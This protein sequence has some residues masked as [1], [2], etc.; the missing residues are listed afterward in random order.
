MAATTCVVSPR[1]T[2]F[3]QRRAVGSEL[4]SHDAVWS[5][6]VLLQELPHQLERRLAVSPRLNQNIQDLAFLSQCPRGSS[7]C[8]RT[9]ARLQN[10]SPNGAPIFKQNRFKFNLI[11]A[12]GSAHFAAQDPVSCHAC[13]AYSQ[14]SY[15]DLQSQR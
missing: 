15:P 8:P 4:V 7:K 5:D 14:S 9:S 11:S 6:A 12:D 10:I 1:N 3:A 2:K 13:A